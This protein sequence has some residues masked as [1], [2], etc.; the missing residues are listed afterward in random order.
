MA[1]LYD[2]VGG[3]EFVRRLVAGFYGRVATDAV[4]RPMYPDDLAEPERKLSLFLSQA[5]GGPSSYSE[6]RGHPRL[7]LRHLPFAI[8]DAARRAWLAAMNAALDDALGESGDVAAEDEAAIRT[9][10]S[11]TAAFLVNRGGLTMR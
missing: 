4:L 8:D 7:R 10:F 1:S 5:F 9:Y 6:E 11:E 2:R 3:D